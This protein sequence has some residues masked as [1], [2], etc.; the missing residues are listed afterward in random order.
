MH[1]EQN[2]ALFN[3]DTARTSSMKRPSVYLPTT[4]IPSEQSKFPRGVVQITFLVCL[5]TFSLQLLSNQ[6]IMLTF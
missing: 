2:F 4:D 5:V 1:D 3:M 6:E